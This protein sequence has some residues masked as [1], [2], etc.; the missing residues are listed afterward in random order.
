VERCRRALAIH[1]LERVRDWTL[2]RILYELEKY[3]GWGQ[4]DMIGNGL[5]WFLAWLFARAACSKVLATQYYRGIMSRYGG[6]AG[7]ALVWP[8]ALAEAATALALLLPQWRLAGLASATA[9]LLLYAGLMA[10]Q[11]LRG[12]SAMDC[13]C[14][15]PGSPLQVS[16][17]LVLR[18]GFC[19][20]LALLAMGL[21]ESA[22]GGWWASLAS[23]TIALG[24]V[25]AYLACEAIIANAQWMEG[26]D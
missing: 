19:A 12:K 16:W 4:L 2:P 10:L 8:L 26:G 20:G 14:S 25:L 3:N 13:G 7:A 24:A 23:V 18:N 17:A 6:A 21:A 1:R 11:I 15:G 9:L 22:A 5:A